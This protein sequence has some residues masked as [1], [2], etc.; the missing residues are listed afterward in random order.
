M[1]RIDKE[2]YPHLY[3]K[4]LAYGR[5]EEGRALNKK[6]VTKYLNSEQGK[7]VRKE[8]QAIGSGRE[9]H[10][11]ANEKYRGTFDGMM[12]RK[13][14]KKDLSEAE[15]VKAIE[16]FQ[17]FDGRCYACGSLDPGGKKGWHLDHKDDKFRGILCHGCNIAA[18]MLRDSP[19]RCD[20]LGLYLYNFIKR[21]TICGS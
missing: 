13:L 4:H 18:G 19:L 15:K 11:E 14:W 2:K 10:R 12:K 9:R 17:N 21:N 7:R 20:L 8:Y 1:R 16:A 5:S 3:K 6:C